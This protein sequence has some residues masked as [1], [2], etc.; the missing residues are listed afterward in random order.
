MT[1]LNNK[2]KADKHRAESLRTANNKVRRSD[3]QTEKEWSKNW[4]GVFRQ[5]MGELN[6]KDR[7]FSR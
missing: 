7:R 6:K 2:R 5:T 4:N 1:E 3:Y